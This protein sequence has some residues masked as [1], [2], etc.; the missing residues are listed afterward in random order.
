MMKKWKRQVQVGVLA[1]MT[2]QGVLLAQTRNLRVNTSTDECSQTVN[3]TAASVDGAGLQ[4]NKWD[5]T[6]APTVNE[7]S[8]DGYGVGSVWID[9]TGD[10]AYICV[11]PTPT[12][13]V[14]NAIDGTAGGFLLDDG[15][16][17]LTAG[18]DVGPYIITALN[19][20]SDVT[21]G[22]QPYATAS[23][24]VNTNLNADL[25]D[26][27]SASAF[28][29]AD[30]GL[31]DI[32]GLAVTDGN[33]IVGDGANWV[34]ESGATAR[35]SLG[36]GTA[37]TPQFARIGLG[38]ASDGTAQLKLAYDAAA[39]ML[40]T[41]AD[42]AGITFAGTSDGLVEFTFNAALVPGDSATTTTGAVRVNGGDIE[43]YVGAAW[44][45]LTG[46]TTGG[47]R[48]IWVDAGACIPRATNGMAAV[49]EEYTTNDV[50]SDHFLADDTTSE[51]VQ[52]RVA[53]PDEWDL[54]T[55]KYKVYW[56]ASSGASASDQVSWGVRA[57]AVGNDDPIDGA[58]GTAVT[59]D[60]V[61]IAVGDL[62]VAPASAALTVGGTPALGDFITW[63][64][65]RNAAGNDDMTEDAK[66]LGIEI[67]Y[68]ESNSEPVIW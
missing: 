52:F 30:A 64:V 43:G 7:D 67:Q 26:G 1:L 2:L 23:T 14:W 34:A 51:A 9:V 37:D 48:T 66:F 55:V 15:T 25:L 46:A 18:W 6:A 53:M 22:T 57:A 27:E 56:D 61:V 50:M 40:I 41:Q 13:A 4:L 65:Y 29:D 8:G 3:F 5:A 11:D 10:A 58:W 44:V 59:V 45:S 68:K 31:T 39:Y 21:T 38:E 28:Q 47:Y 42:G 24:T 32:A 16:V 12:A 36:L 49:T 62:H 19:Y 60:D 35:T 20:V 17:P 63:E 33:I 54:S